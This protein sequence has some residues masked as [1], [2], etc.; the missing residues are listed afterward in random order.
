MAIMVIII[1]DRINMNIIIMNNIKD[2]RDGYE[3]GFQKEKKIGLIISS[4]P[5]EI[6]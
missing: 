3:I 6:V 2:D 4:F 5:I 1:M